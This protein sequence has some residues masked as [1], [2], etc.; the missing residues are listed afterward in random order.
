MKRFLFLLIFIFTG[1]L[2]ADSLDDISQELDE[3]EREFWY[4]CTLE[5]VG[6][7]YR[8]FSRKMAL[9]TISCR[10][11]QEKINHKNLNLPNL[12]IT[13]VTIQNILVDVRQK[14]KSIRIPRISRNT[15]L[16]RFLR[17]HRCNRH[18]YNNS[19]TTKIDLAAYKNWLNEIK[20]ENENRFENSIF[21]IN[22]ATKRKRISKDTKI[23]R[24][25]S[26][27]NVY[28]TNIIKLRYDIA[29]L[30]QNRHHFDKF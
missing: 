5:R 6:E 22:H 11:I 29:V 16:K 15:S 13:S 14:D 28:I 26:L 3:I 25:C 21:L 7:R 18:F 27:Y 1:F 20:I 12:T 30:K 19:D 4:V 17:S 9:F 2:Y 10:K 24:L 8:N 23:K